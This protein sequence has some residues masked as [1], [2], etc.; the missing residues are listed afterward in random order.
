M[1][2]LLEGGAE[3]ELS[4]RVTTDLHFEDCEL[5]NARIPRIS[6]RISSEGAVWKTAAAN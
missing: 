1:Q 2:K 3:G 6:Q 5:R 4:L